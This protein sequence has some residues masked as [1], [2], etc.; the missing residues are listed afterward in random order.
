MSLKQATTVAAQNS[1]WAAYEYAGKLLEAGKNFDSVEVFVLSEQ[2]LV[3]RFHLS[4][5][6]DDETLCAQR[7]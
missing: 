3:R 2:G 6:K 1:T 4:G 7:R 5:G